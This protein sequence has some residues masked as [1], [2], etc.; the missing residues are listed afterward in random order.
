MRPS[1]PKALKYGHDNLLLELKKL[2]NTE[3]RIG[4]KG[5]VL[6]AVMSPHF[7]KEEKF[8]LPPLGLLLALSEGSWKIDA[9]EAIRMSDMLQAKLSEF[10]KE[11]ENIERILQEL[12]IVADEEDNFNAKQFVEDL[13]QHVEIEDQIL[14]PTTILIG[15]YLK[16]MSQD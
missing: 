7:E 1:I 15:N 4:E 5:K 3:G 2:V 14:Y 16:K 11:H 8:A 10:K 13:Q 12:K 9:V 6:D